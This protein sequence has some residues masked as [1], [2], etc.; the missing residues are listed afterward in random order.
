[1]WPVAFSATSPRTGIG[2]AVIPISK[3]AAIVI[4]NS[5]LILFHLLL[6]WMEPSET[7]LTP[8]HMFVFVSK[9][10]T[11]GFLRDKLAV[12]QGYLENLG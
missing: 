8:P 9:H 5:L 12:R 11:V 1:M 3:A 4:A 7:L 10:I 6:L 2:T